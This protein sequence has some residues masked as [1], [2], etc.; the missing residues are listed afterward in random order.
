ML[1]ESD[2]AYEY[3]LIEAPS[4]QLVPGLLSPR[5]SPAVFAR[6]EVVHALRRIRAVDPL[7]TTAGR[8]GLV[9]VGSSEVSSRA[10]PGWRDSSRRAAVAHLPTREVRYDP[11]SLCSSQTHAACVM[12]GTDLG[13][14]L[15]DGRAMGVCSGSN[16]KGHLLGFCEA[17]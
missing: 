7:L 9:L 16:K 3:Q 12:L 10:I 11:D 5:C 13:D 17:L 15:R 2:H 4:R 8:R 1:I 6:L 14:R